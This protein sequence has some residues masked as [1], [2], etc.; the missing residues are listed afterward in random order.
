MGIKLKSFASA[1]VMGFAVLFFGPATSAAKADSF[2]PP[3]VVH[4]TFAPVR[5]RAYVRPYRY[6]RAYPRPYRAY[7]VVRVFAPLPFPHWV[8]RRVYYGPY[9]PGPYAPY[10]GAYRPY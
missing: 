10:A 7:R 2:A 6:A 3:V 4:Q 1:L 9:A 8:F 5:H